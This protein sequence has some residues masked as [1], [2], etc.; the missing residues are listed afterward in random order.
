MRVSAKKVGWSKC[1]LVASFFWNSERERPG[2]SLTNLSA[3]LGL[4][5]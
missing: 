4:P 2:L 3:L 5:F 1:F